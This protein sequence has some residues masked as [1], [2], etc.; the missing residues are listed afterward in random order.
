MSDF[1]DVIERV[2]N[3]EKG[4]SFSSL[5][6]FLKSPRHYWAYNQPKESTQAMDEGT[7]FHMAVLE[8]DKFSQEYWV[9]DDTA[10]ITKLINGGAK[11]PRATK[12]YKEWRSV[13]YTKHKGVPIAKDLY[14]TL[15]KMGE[16]LNQN[17]ATKTLLKNLITKE[18]FFNFLHNGFKIVGK[19][20]GVG[21]IDKKKY[22]LDLKKVADA[23]YDKLRWKIKEM[24][25]HMQG[26]IYTKSEG[27]DTHYL[28]CIDTSCNVTVI[29][30]TKETLHLGL[31][32]FNYALDKF[33]QC[34]EEDLFS[35]S[36]EFYN[37]GY[38][39]V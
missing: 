5:V 8:P 16:Y 10:I 14:N 2:L 23:S 34:A 38:I 24:R 37:G 27:C 32:E 29:R 31:T 4:L 25:Y 35:S 20:D 12:D 11:N 36:Y 15:M 21:R 9:M 3:G 22:T 39:N 13:E 18:K 28:I 26:A 6:E 30:Y 1:N 19:I 17:T 7:M 33:Q